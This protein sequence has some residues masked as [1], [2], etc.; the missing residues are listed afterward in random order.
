MTVSFLTLGCKVNQYE[1]EA[2]SEL[3]EQEGIKTLPFGEQTDAV[4]INTCAVT[5]E[6]ERKARQMIR[7]AIKKNPDA[8]VAVTGCSAQLHPDKLEAID[9]VSL[10]VGNGQK[11]EVVKALLAYR[12]G[13]PFPKR[14]ERSFSLDRFEDMTIMKSERTRAYIKIEDGC[15]SHCAYCIIKNARGKVRSKPLAAVIDETIRLLQNGYREIVLTGIETSDYGKDIGSD[16]VTLLEALEALDS[17]CQLRIERNFRLRLGS[18]DPF[19]FREEVI[20]RLSKLAHLC[21]HFHLSLQS[22]CSKTLAA[23][24]RKCSAEMM[25]EKI[26]LL[27]RY[28]PD[29]TFTADIIVGF[30]GESEEDFHK[31][32]AFLEE[33]QLLDCH[34]FTFSPRPGTEAATLPDQ[35]PEEVKSKRE[36]ALSAILQKTKGEIYAAYI[37][38]TVSVLFEEE[39]D[40]RSLGHTDTFLPVAVARFDH[41][42]NTLYPVKITAMENGRLYGEIVR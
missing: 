28:L 7:R 9:G 22:G 33:V 38:K 34:I 16:L 2:L 10:V 12:D 14:D 42:H 32:T 18:L 39:K 31:T 35:I 4:V 25:K 26:A 36:K 21:H 29:V 41:C 1:S 30:P 15:D 6:G 19:F 5:A 27:R 3:L 24:R 17:N 23:M 37:G 40:A 11:K 8:F 20:K 13:K